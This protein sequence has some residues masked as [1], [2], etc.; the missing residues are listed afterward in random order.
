M[1][2]LAFIITTLALLTLAIFY[3]WYLNTY[4]STNLLNTVGYTS[5]LV[6]TA[7]THEFQNAITIASMGNV[8]GSFNY[9]L[10]LPTS[11]IP[12]QGM[13]LTY[14][15]TLY[16]KEENNLLLL[17]A[18]LTVT[19]IMGPLSRTIKNNVLVYSSTQPYKIVAYNC[20]NNPN[21]PLTLVDPSWLS[22]GPPNLTPSCTWVSSEIQMGEAVIGISKG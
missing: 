9:T 13:A 8:V 20:V 5:S 4:I 15:I 11:A 19:M 14:T 6:S 10:M 21:Q 22:Q 17:Y 7:L 2:T 1:D 12:V 3:V 18:N 16:P